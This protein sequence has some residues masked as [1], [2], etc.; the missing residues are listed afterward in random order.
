MRT[1]TGYVIYNVTC[2]KFLTSQLTWSA[3]GSE[4]FADPF[5]FEDVELV[6]KE[7][8]SSWKIQPVY[9]MRATFSDNDGVKIIGGIEPL[10]EPIE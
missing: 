10:W 1:I 9:K 3:V 4:Y 6:K 8:D 7:Y 2:D 5:V